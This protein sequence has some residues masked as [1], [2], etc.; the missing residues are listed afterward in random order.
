[1][2]ARRPPPDRQG[3]PPLPLCVVA[4]DV[5]GGGH[6][7]TGAR[8][9]PRWLS[10][11]VRSC[12]SRWSPLVPR[13]AK[14]GQAD[15]DRPRAAHLGLRV[16]AV[17]YHLLRD[18]PLGTDGDFSYESIVARYNSDS[19]TTWATWS[20][21]WRRWSAPSA[22]ASVRRPTPTARS[23]RRPKRRASPPRTR[24]E[25]FARTRH[26][27]PRAAHRCG[28]RSLRGHRAVEG[29][30]RPSGRRRARQRLDSWPGIVT[31]LI[32][33]AMPRQPSHL[34]AHRSQRLTRRERLPDA[35]AWGGYPGGLAVEKG[36]PLFPR[37]KP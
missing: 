14:G 9:R 5:H 28:E 12:P 26:S 19:R 18:T 20:R 6:R 36:A 31:L 35:A 17:R 4:G 3:D 15:R 25:R 37:R 21:G 1:M 22:G 16:D 30:T 7:P 33:P 10:S 23:A 24:W 13:R 2:V 34:G 29:R 32:T 11:A 27:R 8:L